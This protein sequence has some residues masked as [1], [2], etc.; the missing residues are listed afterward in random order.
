[1]T[2]TEIIVVDP[3]EE[4]LTLAKEWRADETVQV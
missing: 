3:S 4:A 1:M 2:P